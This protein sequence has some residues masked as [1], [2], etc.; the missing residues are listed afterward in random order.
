M[1]GLID[2]ETPSL[3]QGKASIARCGLLN[4]QLTAGV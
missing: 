2:L 4:K 3:L 1:E